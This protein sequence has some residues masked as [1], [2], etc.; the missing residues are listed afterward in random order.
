MRDASRIITGIQAE[1]KA[2]I[3]TSQYSLDI[4]LAI[5]KMVTGTE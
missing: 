5:A 4:T 1:F 2:N 3:I